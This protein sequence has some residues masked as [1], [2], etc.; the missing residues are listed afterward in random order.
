MHLAGQKYFGQGQKRM[1]SLNKAARGVLYIP[2]PVAL[3]FVIVFAVFLKLSFTRASIRFARFLTFPRG[4]QTDAVHQGGLSLG[5][6]TEDSPPV[7]IA[8]SWCSHCTAPTVW[9]TKKSLPAICRLL[10]ASKLMCASCA[11]ESSIFFCFCVRVRGWGLGW[12]IIEQDL[13]FP[14]GVCTHAQIW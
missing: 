2:A 8:A 11:P 5:T 7:A 1:H 3:V 14:D 9:L 13:H 6:C 10:F 12:G 4:V